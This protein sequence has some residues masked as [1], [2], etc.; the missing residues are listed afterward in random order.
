MAWQGSTSNPPAGAGGSGS[1]ATSDSCG[2]SSSAPSSPAITT[3][4]LYVGARAAVPLPHVLV[5]NFRRDFPRALIR[6][7]ASACLSEPA[8][9]P[10]LSIAGPADFY[11]PTLPP[12]LTLYIGKALFFGTELFS[13][14]R[15]TWSTRPPPDHITAA[16]DHQTAELR[17]A[18]ALLLMT[19]R[20]PGSIPPQAA[21]NQI[22]ARPGGWGWVYRD[23]SSSSPAG[24][25]AP[26]V[27]HRSQIGRPHLGFGVVQK[28][29]QTLAPET[30]D[31]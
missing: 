27:A 16:F 20:S 25:A 30:E 19:C 18:N 15:D 7:C 12:H 17:F 28:T 22:L 9:G 21:Q 31:Q 11:C 4:Y 1:G 10:L 5:G 6:H 3:E 29:N 23:A 8:Q 14:R 13:F 26:S 24:C 2:V